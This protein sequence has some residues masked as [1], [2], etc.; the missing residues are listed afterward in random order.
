[1]KICSLSSGSKGNSLY[2]ES[3]YGR[4]LI[5]VGLSA[6]QICKRL[7]SI[8]V[9]PASINAIVI[10]HAH[11]DHVHGVGVFSKQFNTPIYGHPETLDRI[12]YLLKYQQTLVPWQHK[13]SIKDFDLTPFKVSHDANPTVGYLV[14]SGNNRF[15]VCT[16][17]GVVT[18]EVVENLSQAQFILLESNHDPD[19][20]MNGSYPWDLKERITSRVGHLSNHETGL[21]LKSV[22]NGSIRQI[23]LGHVSEENNTPE[24]AKNTVLEYIGPIFSDM[25]EVL[26]QRKVSKIFEF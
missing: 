12:S 14:S 16:D 24:L 10:T 20:L 3:E 8:E 4:L 5:D 17:L 2:I 1:M 7:E 9:D 26:E 15:A 13:F 19:M 21:L 18:P 25:V 23:L 22:I 11:R 6:R